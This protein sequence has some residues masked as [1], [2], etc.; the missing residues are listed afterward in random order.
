MVA[1]Q[2]REI[3]KFTQRPDVIS[4]AG[5]L[6]NPQAFPIKELAEISSDVIINNGA[7]ALQYGTTEGLSGLR[8]DIVEMMKGWNIKT[9]IENI[10][11]TEGSQQGL[12]LLGKVFL[13][14]ED[15]IIVGGPSYIGALNAFRGFEADMISVPLD[16][17]G[18][19]IDILEEKL[20]E[21]KRDYKHI[22]FVYLVPTFQ[23][24]AGVTMS[25]SRRRKVLEL[26]EDYDILIIEDNPYGEL[27][28]NGEDIMPIKSM[29]TNERVIYL[30]TFSKIL[31]PGLRMAFIIAPKEFYRKIV[32]AK[33]SADLCTTTLTQYIVHEYIQRGYMKPHI[34]KIKEL[35]GRKRDIMLKAL[36]EHFPEG[37]RWTKPDGGMFTWA[38]LAE[39]IDTTEM[40]PKAIDKKVAYIS[41]SSFYA[42]H[43]GKNTMR[44]NFTHSSDEL[45]E[46]GV[47][48]L[49][50]VIQE[51]MKTGS[52]PNVPISP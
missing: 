18:M 30:G 46:D 10:C 34:E 42:D 35:Y 33:Q 25:E 9:H 31:S 14:P 37:T 11:I 27:R 2:I 39:N 17:N 47:K 32:I 23:N 21:C 49:S 20:E 29:D 3:L 13:N 40:F 50:C 15:K 28:Y 38:T 51:E 6:P 8:S 43:S 5:G 26:A 45:I 1:S 22:K 12:E 19:I 52:T 16:D 44:L 41:G 36:D 24:P 7:A 4:F 48:R